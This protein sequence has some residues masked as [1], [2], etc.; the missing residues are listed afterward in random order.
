MRAGLVSS[1]YYPPLRHRMRCATG[2]GHH[3][4]CAPQGPTRTL[5]TRCEL[6]VISVG[7]YDVEIRSKTLVTAR[8]PVNGAPKN[9]TL[10]L[11]SHPS[12]CTASADRIDSA[13][14]ADR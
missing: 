9:L 1:E 10:V 5:A 7:E 12:M 4:R 14:A 13:L 2:I 8:S 3:I 6:I 11:R